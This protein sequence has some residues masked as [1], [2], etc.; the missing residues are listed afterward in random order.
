M[1]LTASP[2]SAVAVVL[3]P[4]PPPP[5]VGETY[6]NR[7]NKYSKMGK[8]VAYE[9]GVAPA[10]PTMTTCSGRAFSNVARGDYQIPD[11]R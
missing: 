8:G 2:P 1:T 11:R 6:E 3:A 10:P 4:R 5:A 9:N 7:D